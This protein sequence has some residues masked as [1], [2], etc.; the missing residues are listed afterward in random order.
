M[1]THSYAGVGASVTLKRELIWE[2][3]LPNKGQEPP[4]G[5]QDV[6]VRGSRLGYG[7]AQLGVAQ[8]SEDGEDASDGPH[9]QRQPKRP[10]V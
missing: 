6:G 9:H 4:E 2:A 3:N 1:H 8:R 10:G 7:G 5:L